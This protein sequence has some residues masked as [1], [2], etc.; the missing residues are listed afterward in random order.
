MYLIHVFP[1]FSLFIKSVGTNIY[2]LFF[3]YRLLLA[4]SMEDS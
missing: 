3:E 2:Y 1:P 4:Q